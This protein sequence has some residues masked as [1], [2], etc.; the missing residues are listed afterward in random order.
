MSNLL[1]HFAKHQQNHFRVVFPCPD[2]LAS[3]LPADENFTGI[4]P[5]KLANLSSLGNH[6]SICCN[7]F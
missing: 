6:R 1:Y 2:D 4:I 5:A 3:L 7:G